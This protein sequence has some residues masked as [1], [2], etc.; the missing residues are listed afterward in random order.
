MSNHPLTRLT[1]RLRGGVRTCANACSFCFIDQLPSNL[2]SSLYLKDDDYRLSFRDGTFITLTNLSSADVKRI[3]TQ[4][5]SPLY[6]SFHASDPTVR[7][8]LLGSNALRTLDV[9]DRLCEAGIEL[10]VSIVLVPGINDGEVLDE[11]LAYLAERRPQVLSVGIVP[12]AYT[13]Y[14]ER[15]AE[16]A[17]SEAP[18]SFND[19]IAAAHVIEQV[20]RYQFASRD[21]TGTTWVYLADEFYIYAQAPF[22]TTEWYDGYPQYENG[23]GIVHAFVDDIR[24]HFDELTAAFEAI[25]D[26]SEA[27][28]L[29]TGEL[30]VDTMIGTLSA[31]RAGGK[32]RLL[33]I[34]NY[35]LG[36]N[37]GV[38]GL[39]TATDIVAGISFDAER[40]ARTAEDD[41]VHPVLPTTYVIPDAIFNADGLT[42]D[43]KTAEDIAATLATGDISVMF[44]S[45]D[46]AGLLRAAQAAAVPAVKTADEAEVICD[47]PSTA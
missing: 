14:S 32:A 34:R 18:C 44:V 45:D 38:T 17:S 33:P 35:F 24:L 22:P 40:I 9:F 43:G 1:E 23:I 31:L 42:L 12:V 26:E 19:P 39:L 41:T 27:L 4:Q 37:V 8:A 10:H 15:T 47:E 11:T 36:G 29:L 25:P 21:E 3:V 5:L 20:Q 2:R 13:K 7:T 16:A 28:T 46:A 6:V 30:T